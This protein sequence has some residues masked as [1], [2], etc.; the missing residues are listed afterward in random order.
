MKYRI[1]VSNTASKQFAH[2]DRITQGRVREHIEA[3]ADNPH[4]PGSRKLQGREEAHWRI[5]VGAYRVIYT[6]ENALLY[7][8]VIRIAHRREVYR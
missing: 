1:E 7:V 2:L 6:V 3:L 4:P 5:R 8:L